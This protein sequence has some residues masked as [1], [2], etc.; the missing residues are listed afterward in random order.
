MNIRPHKSLIKEIAPGVIQ[1]GSNAFAPVLSLDELS[2]RATFMNQEIV[3]AD[4]FENISGV[5]LNYG[6]GNFENRPTAEGE[7]I[8]LESDLNTGI[9]SLELQISEEIQLRIDGDIENLDSINTASGV[10][11]SGI[12]QEIQDRI[13]GDQDVLDQLI[14][15]SGILSSEIDIVENEISNVSGVLNQ[16]ISEID[17]VGI[18]YEEAQSLAKKWAIILG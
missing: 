3:L 13:D 10:L 6:S 9:E 8:V 17:N 2:S 1:I 15:A 14:S 11:N 16:Q 18:T 12:S 5:T 7:D 4:A